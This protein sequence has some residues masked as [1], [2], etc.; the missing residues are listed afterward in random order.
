LVHIT[1]TSQER[2]SKGPYSTASL[3]E[4]RKLMS[5]RDKYYESLT[6]NDMEYRMLKT[7]VTLDEFRRFAVDQVLEFTKDEITILNNAMDLMERLIDER[8]ITLSCGKV[9]FV[10]TTMKEEGGALAYTHGNEIYLGEQILQDKPL[11]IVKT[12]SHE[13][14]HVISASNSDLRQKMYYLIGFKIR[15]REF[16]IPDR[17]RE[18]FITNPDVPRHDAYATFNLGGTKF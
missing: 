8:G 2:S 6:Q 13:L 18:L 4:G 9:V 14:W 17:I 3:E 1:S 10:K 7:G 5:G 16:D 12:V 11:E 15:D